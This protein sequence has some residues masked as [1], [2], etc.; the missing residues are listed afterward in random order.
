M[1]VFLGCIFIPLRAGGV[2]ILSVLVCWVCDVC[3]MCI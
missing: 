1:L 3:G 2:G